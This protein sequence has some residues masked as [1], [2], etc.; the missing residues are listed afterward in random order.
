MRC[1]HRPALLQ[2]RHCDRP[3]RPQD[4]Q[5]GACSQLA[6]HRA[7]YFAQRQLPCA[8]ERRPRS[9]RRHH[10]RTRGL[11]ATR[12]AVLPNQLAQGHAAADC[13]AASAA[14]TAVCQSCSRWHAS[15]RPRCRRRPCRQRRG[16][17]WSAHRLH[18]PGSLAPRCR[19]P[20][21]A[22]LFCTVGQHRR[23]TRAADQRDATVAW[24]GR[25]ASKA[26]DH[27]SPSLHC[28]PSSALRHAM[29]QLPFARPQTHIWGEQLPEPQSKLA[30]SP[31][32]AHGHCRLL[33]TKPSRVD[34]GMREFCT[35]LGDPAARKRHVPL[36]GTLD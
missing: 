24:Q 32:V 27:S 13:Q 8:P 4:N 35:V 17:R 19:A 34:L 5:Q 9:Q 36:T 2:A 30:A 33:P 6:A 21:Q 10:H 11:A 14:G 31:C 3:S 26:T 7:C 25:R 29:R 1:S 16:C 20:W 18:E 22:P 23:R 12:T 28:D 15:G